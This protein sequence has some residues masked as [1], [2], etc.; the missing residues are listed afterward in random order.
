VLSV[1]IG[2]LG[3][4]ILA[5][6]GP[7]LIDPRLVTALE[8]PLRIEILSILRHGPSSP[9]RI[10][11]QMENVSLNLVSHHI[12]VLK[13]LGCIE[14]VE[15]VKRRGAREHIYRAAGPSILGDEEFEELTPK[16]RYRLTTSIVRAISQDLTGSLGT[17]LFDKVPASHVSRSPLKLDSLGSKEV[18]DVLLRALE[19]VLE[20]GHRNSSRLESS[21]EEGVPMTIAIM[22]FP[23]VSGGTEADD[24]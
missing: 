9:A 24:A 5:K 15:T 2:T 10:Q 8:H 22:K 18:T 4:D 1:A 17:G 11:R 19:E 7:E 14:L 16:A 13:D 20:I 3:E 23:T 6:R 12:K 21:G